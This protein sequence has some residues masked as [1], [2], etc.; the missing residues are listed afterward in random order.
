MRHILLLLVIASSL[1]LTSC[2]PESKFAVE[3]PETYVF[4]R[5]GEST[6]SFSG[7]STRIEMATELVEAMKDFDSS[8]AILNEIYANETATGGDANPYANQE[9]NES[10][11]SVR[12][13]VAAS[14]D[15]F[16]TN[17]VESLE[18][19]SDFSKWI[20][21]QV[22]EVF[23]NRNK[24]AA[25]GQAGQI[26]D[27]GTV[28]YV[29]AKG[30]EYDQ[31]V[32]KGL[33]GGLMVDQML[34]NYLSIAVLD[35]A[36]N[37]SNNSSSVVVEGK[38][39]TNME[40]KWDEAY[41]YLFGKSMDTEDPLLTLG[42]DSFLNKYLK[43]VDEDADFN[44]IASNIFEALKLGR[45]AIV[46]EDYNTRD[47]QINIIKEQVSSVIGIRAVYYLQ[48]A[49]LA[50]INNDFGGAFHDLSEGFGFVYSLR[51]TRNPNSNDSYFTKMEVDTFIQLLEEDQGFW[52]ITT[53]TLDQ[54]STD[55]ASKFSFTVEQ[56]GS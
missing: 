7:Q 31:A 24:L 20:Y 34:N 8:I 42:D 37:V 3:N 41:G 43:R 6:V 48:Q 26:D 53:E 15:F 29:S 50:L 38:T 54:I 27:G 56:A 10:T 14:K 23:P 40:H 49:K 12:S 35:E 4:E 1:I 52:S 25:E 47:K 21:A 18:I 51:F 55:I 36:D 44:G 17:A 16:S 45:A 9:L 33:I 2:D 13:K 19:K 5:N 39:Y 11:K 32:N 46:A 30:L 28:R 22:N